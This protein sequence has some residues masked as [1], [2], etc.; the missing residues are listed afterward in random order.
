MKKFML[1]EDIGIVENRLKEFEQKTGCDLL[2]V[3]TNA[4]DPYPG[5]SWRFAFVASFVTTF[6]FSYYFEFHHSWMWP[7]FMATISLLMYFLGRL[8]NLK[9]LALSDWETAR[10]C[11]EKAIEYF[12]NLGTSK[13]HHK[14]TAMIMISILERNIQVLVDEKLKKEITQQELNELVEI[15]KI[16]FKSGNMTRGLLNSIENLESKILKDFGGKVSTN[17]HSEL[18]DKIQFIIN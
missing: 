1:Q 8:P 14:V 11:K 12:H 4:S 2:L 3:V 7:V 17:H 16:Q 5:A 10:E 15:M 18:S 6:I 9:Q 13:V